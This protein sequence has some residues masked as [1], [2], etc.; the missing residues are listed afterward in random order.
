[1]T[2][3][4]GLRRVEDV[5]DGRD[6]GQI[7]GCFLGVIGAHRGLALHRLGVFLRLQAGI[8]EAEDELFARG[9]VVDLEDCAVNDDRVQIVAFGTK[10]EQSGRRET[11]RDG[12]ELVALFFEKQGRVVHGCFLGFLAILIIEADNGVVELVPGVHAHSYRSLGD[13]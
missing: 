3:G 9:D 4:L 7:V 12:L 11:V 2:R 10:P 13:W 1:M 8:D 5:A 6:G